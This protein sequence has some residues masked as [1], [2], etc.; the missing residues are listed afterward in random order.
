[1]MKLKSNAEPIRM[2]EALDV[3]STVS[4]AVPVP[5][6]SA[7]ASSM[8]FASIS[9]GLN[10]TDTVTQIYNWICSNISYD[11]AAWKHG[12]KEFT[13]NSRENEDDISLSRVLHTRKATCKGYATLFQAMCR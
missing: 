6:S 8:S 11:A 2:S 1:M 3:A 10:E 9:D 7:I 4:P 5:V 13:A 12:I